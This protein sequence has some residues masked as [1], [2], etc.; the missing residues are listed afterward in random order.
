MYLNYLSSKGSNILL[1]YLNKVAAILAIELR[2]SI[3][4][5]SN[6]INIVIECA[7]SIVNYKVRDSSKVYSRQN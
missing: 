3:S 6:A 7:L 2:L 4:V 1:C 5:V